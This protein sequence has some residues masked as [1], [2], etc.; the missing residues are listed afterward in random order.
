MWKVSRPTEDEVLY[1][2][3]SYYRDGGLFII[4]EDK[5]KF[6]SYIYID[7]IYKE[8]ATDKDMGIL[9]LKSLLCLKKHGFKITSA[10]IKE[11]TK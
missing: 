7:R 2:S 9:K 8:S 4:S 1:E 6:R 10:D 3:I 11:M 5:N